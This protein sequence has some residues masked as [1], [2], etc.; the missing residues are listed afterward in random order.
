MDVTRW[1]LQRIDELC[2]LDRL[3]EC[4]RARGALAFGDGAEIGIDTPVLHGIVLYWDIHHRRVKQLADLNFDAGLF[5][6]F[7]RSRFLKGLATFQSD[8]NSQQTL[9]NAR[10]R[11]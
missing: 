10:A 3:I 9:P 7:A 2:P 6:R 4:T 5:Q 8:G 1:K 11:L